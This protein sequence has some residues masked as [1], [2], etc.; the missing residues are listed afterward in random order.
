MKPSPDAAHPAGNPE[1][2]LTETLDSFWR[3][4]AFILL[5]GTLSRFFFIPLVLAV[6]ILFNGLVESF[7]P[8][9]AGTSSGLLLWNGEIKHDGIGHCRHLVVALGNNEISLLSIRALRLLVGFALNASQIIARQQA[10]N[11]HR[12][13]DRRRGIRR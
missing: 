11:V 9:N 10:A 2:F 5:T 3:R 12:R 8:Q 4:S 6:A 1:R 13:L 7:I